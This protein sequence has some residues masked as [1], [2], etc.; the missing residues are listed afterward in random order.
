MPNAHV[1]AASEAAPA[2]KLPESFLQALLKPLPGSV[3]LDTEYNLLMRQM[4]KAA[5]READAKASFMHAR[6]KF[7]RA[8]ERFLSVGNTSPKMDYTRL[9]AEKRAAIAAQILVP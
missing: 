1:R 6:I 3:L 5:W 2:H 4:R 8:G 7:M 9:I